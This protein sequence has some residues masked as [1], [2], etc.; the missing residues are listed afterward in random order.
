MPAAG[1]AELMGLALDR[2]TMEEALARCLAWCEGPRRTHTVVTVNASHVSLA[3]RDPELRA[4][5]RAGDLVLADGMP[6]VWSARLL[7]AALPERVSG[8]D[9]MPRLLAEAGR[10]SLRVYFL[11]ARPDVV[12]DLAARSVR[13]HPG[14]VLAGFRDGYFSPA[15]HAAIVEEIRRAEPHLLFVG[16][17]SPFKETW[18]ERHRA[19]LAVP[20]VAGV[21]GTF[22]V[23]AGRVRRAPPWM[24]RSGLEW[25]WR[26][27]MEPRRMWRRYLATNSEFLWLAAREV[28]RRRATPAEGPAGEAGG[29]P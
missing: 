6:V 25:S 16:M 28:V 11:G 9:L 24:Q 1:R 17:P 3:R 4:A 29:A 20:V 22:D 23:L 13:A 8:C 12:S 18:C 15:D 26:L 27:L 5:C 2:A 19:R 10:R 21:G 7:G 14:L